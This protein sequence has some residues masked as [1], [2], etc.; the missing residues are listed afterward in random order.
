MRN[1]RIIPRLD[2]KGPNLVKGI[3]LEGLRVIGKPEKFAKYYYENGAD[4]LL[5]MD[6]VAS[7]YGRNS[8][9]EIIQKT[10]KEIF[11][12]L[13]VGGGLRTLADIRRVLR[14]GADKVSLNTAAIQRPELIKEAAEEFGS[15]TIVVSIE[16]IKMPDGSYEAYTDNGRE[17]TGVDAIGWA[18]RVEELGAGEILLT[19]IDQEGT[20]RGF[21]F[22][23]VCTI[24][25][26]V[27]IPV[28]ACGGAGNIEHIHQ[29]I[30]DA[31]AD[32]VSIASIL[33]YNFIRH[34]PEIL[35]D[36]SSEGN[37]EFLKSRREFQRI[38]DAPLPEIKKY[39]FEQGVA[40]R[41]NEVAL[42]KEP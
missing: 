15:S 37:I 40:C 4:E 2:I 34:H 10:S 28:I 19:S 14:C 22:E 11:I 20:G 25:G 24:A 31:K 6:V 41:F 7:L 29:V 39:L 13:T 16:A 17:K 18:K 8:L 3:H 21:D 1:I 23:L 42:S 12:P 32:A 5:Y 9:D 26:L 33:H 35:D 27:S 30:S 36:F 38:Q